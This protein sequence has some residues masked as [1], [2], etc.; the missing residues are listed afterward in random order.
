M[1]RNT[2][3]RYYIVSDIF[4]F[5]VQHYA[6]LKLVDVV[7]DKPRASVASDKYIQN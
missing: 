4:V 1:K 2:V 3:T 7:Y 5:L 6:I